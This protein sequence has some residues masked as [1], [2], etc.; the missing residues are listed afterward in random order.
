[1]SRASELADQLRKEARIS[2]RIF[3]TDERLSAADELERLE[4]VNAELA[5]AMKVIA[6]F[7]IT[8]ARNMDAENM[9]ALA[10]A[11]LTSATK[12]QP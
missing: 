4:R 11:A 5:T 7:P 10:R 8:D 2:P 1:M 3:V 12:E 9:S 6:S